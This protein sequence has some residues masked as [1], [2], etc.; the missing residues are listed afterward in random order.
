MVALPFISDY[1]KIVFS[2]MNR[3]YVIYDCDDRMKFG[4]DDDCGFCRL[5]ISH[6]AG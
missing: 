5:W 2:V 3:Y 1:E 4:G 6:R